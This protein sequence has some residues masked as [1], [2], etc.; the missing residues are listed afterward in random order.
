MRMLKLLDASSPLVVTLTLAFGSMLLPGCNVNVKKDSEG[1]EKKVDIE[2]PI[3][4]LHVSKNADVRDVGL[5]VYP[6]ARRKE[7]KEDGDEHSAN[8]N[9]SSSL[10][11]LKVVAVEYSSDDRPEKLVAYYKDQLKKY[12]SVLECHVNKSHA[13]ASMDPDDDSSE[14]KQLKCEGDSNGKIIELKAGTRQSQHIVSIHPADSGK[15][16]DFG[17]VYVQVRGGKDTI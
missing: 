6:G 16:C 5:S 4:G 12:G 9:I 2:T 3:G 7:T 15:E 11:G 1:Q 13:G 10:F 8:V 17:L 14:S